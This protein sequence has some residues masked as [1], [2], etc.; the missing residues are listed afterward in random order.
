MYFVQ[1][2]SAAA[3]AAISGAHQ[4]HVRQCVHQF[5][6]GPEVVE[7]SENC[8]QFVHQR[9]REI[10]PVW[11]LNVLIPERRVQ[12][13]AE[14]G[15]GRGVARRG[16]AVGV[17]EDGDCAVLGDVGGVAQVDEVAEVIPEVSFEIGEGGAVDEVAGVS[18]VRAGLQNT[19]LLQRRCDDV[20]AA[21]A[22]QDA[23]P[24]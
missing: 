23:V 18:R 6:V 14:A 24:L 22:Q 16:V 21:R 1:P 11:L 19:S 9:I 17:V 4:R 8:G 13:W 12:P 15:Q 7:A 5:Q 3:H 20:V 2:I 10:V